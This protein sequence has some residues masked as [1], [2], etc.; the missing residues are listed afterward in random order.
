MSLT[1]PDYSN[2]N[3]EE[4]ASVIGLKAKHMPMLITSFLEE[5]TPL[6]SQL[7]DAIEKRDYKTIE[8]ASHS[9]KGSAGNLRFNELSEMA[10]EMEHAGADANSSFDYL[11]YFHA[12][13]EA[14]KTIKV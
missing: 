5:S 13:L 8:S 4:M 7:K 14:V 9:L 10:K 2:L 1:N 11:S 3:H 12:I 6:L